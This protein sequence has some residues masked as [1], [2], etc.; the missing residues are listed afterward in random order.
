M[1][2]AEHPPPHFHVTYNE[3]KCSYKIERTGDL[4][5]L[6]GT[7]DRKVSKKIKDLYENHDLRKRAI[8]TWNKTR[9]DECTVGTIPVH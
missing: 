5:I 2:S 4:E 8:E 9:S 7:M 6:D 3:H 1:Y